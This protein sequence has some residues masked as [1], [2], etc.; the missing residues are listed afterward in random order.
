MEPDGLRRR[1]E[2]VGGDHLSYSLAIL[3]TV[4]ATLAR[5]AL[6]PVV[7]DTLP[8]FTFFL[9]TLFAALVGGLGPGLL[10]TALGGLLGA[11]LFVE[12]RGVLVVRDTGGLARL[13]VF[14]SVGLGI[15]LVAERAHAR[16]RRAKS[17]DAS[18]RRAAERALRDSERRFRGTF[19]N[20]AVGMALIDNKGH[21]MLVNE[22]FRAMLGRSFEDVRGRSF[23]DVTHPD[24]REDDFRR[25]SSMTRG[26]VE[27]D[28]LEKRYLRSDGTAIWALVTR[29]LQ[30]GDEAAPPY[31]ISVVQDITDRQRAEEALRK[32]AAFARRILASSLAGLYVY[33]L[34]PGVITYVSPEYSRLTGYSLE[35][36]RALEG[37]A[38]LQLFH[39]E[40][41]PKVGAHV[42]AAADAGDDEVREIEYRFKRADGR[43]IWCYSRETVFTRN[44][45]GSVRQYLGT[46][47]DTT[48]R[49]Q[50][51]EAL[52]ESELFYRQTLE[53]I[54]GMVFTTR[55]DGYCDYQS[56]QWVEYTGVPMAQH[57]GEGW[58][59][60]L[61]PDDRPRA[62]AAWR[63]AVE[64]DSPYDLEYRVRRHDGVYEW[65]KVIGEPIRDASG[66]IVRW[67]GVA[68]NIE[69]LKR[70]EV[71]LQAARGAAEEA[72][73]AKDHFLAALSHEL[74]TPLTP[75]VAALAILQR[76]G[77]FDAATRDS[78]EI[79]R[80][81]VEMEARLIDDLLDVTRIVR[82]KV[83]LDRRPV[84]FGEVVTRAIEVCR[85]DIE[86]RRL[87]FSADLGP[88]AACI[89]DADAARL[90]QVFWNLLQ[91][92][93]KF[94][95]HG[96]CVGVTSRLEGGRLT[97]E[98][99]DSGEGIDPAVLPH[100]FKPFEQGG[101]RVTRQF[102]GLGLGLA[103]TRGFV[104]M[105]GG[106]ISAHSPG[107]GAGA[108]FRV[109]L[110]VHALDATALP[111]RP[112]ASEPGVRP[113]R[114]LRILLVEDH[115]DTAVMM[116]CLLVTQ[117]HEVE[118][119]GDV[120]TA[121][122]LAES[123]PFD[124]LVS[125]LGLPDG[126]GVDLMRT[127]RQRGHALPGV[128]LSG[129]GQDEDIRRSRE[130]G[131]AA[132]LTKPASPERLL[133]VIDDVAGPLDA[134]PGRA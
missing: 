23:I 21:F 116:Q 28:I 128:A 15:S 101:A 16:R 60:L 61:H 37:P 47:L 131:F 67:F 88:C 19:E 134:G 62:L 112:A 73:R 46:F 11:W 70:A 54:P 4:L 40:D 1:R 71:E 10:A 6:D 121:V 127:L 35:E 100:I 64:G 25:F 108:T 12:P 96:G 29:S 119:A 79:I 38:L 95:P 31:V 56:R 117:G 7:G 5:Y 82:G 106:Q 69:D 55:P 18:E 36:I 42:A 77:R 123:R 30:R 78:L 104:E 122:T 120:S 68:M 132:H 51:E 102:G 39:P 41:R 97:A 32:S 133:E 93:I 50:A 59:R 103:I 8:F 114:P 87:H 44:P 84:P 27:S 72:S 105:H 125:D 63:A 109:V 52:R 48:E 17:A 124:L 58:S 14:L 111:A 126:S 13:L 118:T 57:L 92:A 33:D 76:T 86:A 34:A 98:V 90:Q 26:D 24:D 43:W 85:P 115:G 94:T 130:A 22:R 49:K 66:R 83:E 65:F 2:G 113:K 75:A 129:F 45:D 20:A 89:V 110:P 53:S 81:N 80:R 99:T 91:N 74:R 107:K 9:S 3:A